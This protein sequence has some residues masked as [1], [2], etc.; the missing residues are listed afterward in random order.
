MASLQVECRMH[1]EPDALELLELG[2]DVGELLDLVPD[3][4]IERD[5]LAE[6]IAQR[7][8]GLITITT[9]AGRGT[10]GGAEL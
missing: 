9:G 3:W 4:C 5:A 6:R 7:L 1:F 8:R 10:R 2:R